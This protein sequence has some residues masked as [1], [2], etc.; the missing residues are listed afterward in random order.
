MAANVALVAELE[1]GASAG[2]DFGSLSALSPWSANVSEAH[3]LLAIVE[4]VA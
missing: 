3:C 1:S 2:Q 4:K